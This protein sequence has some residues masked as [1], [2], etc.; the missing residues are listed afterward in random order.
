MTPGNMDAHLACQPH[1]IP[2]RM[3]RDAGFWLLSV[4][5]RD[6]SR[7]RDGLHD[8]CGD[9]T[10]MVGESLNAVSVVEE[11]EGLPSAVVVHGGDALKAILTVLEGVVEE[12]V[13]LISDGVVILGE[14]L[15]EL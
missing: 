9:G 3:A 10:K 11:D 1:I 2:I 4:K 7:E 14:C 5:T 8:L 12:G 13:V 15:A 6:P